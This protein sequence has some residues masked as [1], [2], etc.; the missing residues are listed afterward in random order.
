M[1]GI[2]RGDIRGLWV[3]CTNP[4]HSWINQHQCRDILDRLDF[5]VVQD[6]YRTTD[7]ARLADLLLPAAAWGEKEGTFINSERRI[8]RIK[9][10]HRAPG[11]SLSDFHIFKLVAHYWGCGQ[12][13]EKWQSPESVFQLLKQCT[14]DQPCDFRG[15]SDYAHL[16]MS[17]GIQWPY[18]TEQSRTQSTDS[19]RRLFE[20]GQFYHQ[21]GRARLLYESPRPIVERTMSA[22]PLTLLTG[23][24]SAS[25]WHTQT[26]TGQ[27]DVLRKL[28]P[29]KLFVEINP[30]DATEIGIQPNDT[31]F[32]ESQ[33]G[34]LRAKAVITRAVRAGQVFIP[35]HYHDTNQLTFSAFDPYS[36]QPAYKACAV[37][38]TR[39]N[40]V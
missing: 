25:Q 27:S 7:T 39:G 30:Q 17:G 31:V 21:D 6:M 36:H 12:M 22:Y 38:V 2:L 8:G 14:A 18:P 4:A 28:Y 13:F 16:D 40:V 5:L 20:T 33:R 11:D 10:V 15:I 29:K 9:K 1:D 24:G 26:R 3:I 35:M 37:R 23:R 19:E 34:R 32:V